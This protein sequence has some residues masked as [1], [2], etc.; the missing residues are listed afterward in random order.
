MLRNASSD[1]KKFAK[2]VVN[3]VKNGPPSGVPKLNLQRITE[4]RNEAPVTQP[5]ICPGCHEHHPAR[6]AVCPE[7]PTILRPHNGS[8]W[9]ERAEQVL[10]P[11]PVTFI[12]APT[13]SRKMPHNKMPHNIRG[14]ER[15]EKIFDYYDKDRDGVLCFDELMLLAA[16]VHAE[17]NPDNPPLS[18]SA[19]KE[20]VEDLRRQIEVH[21]DQCVGR[22]NGTVEFEE[23]EPWLQE[24]EM[25]F[26]Q[27]QPRPAVPLDGSPCLR[28]DELRS[29]MNLS[30]WRRL[31]KP[32]LPSQNLSI[33]IPPTDGCVLQR[34][35]SHDHLLFAAQHKPAGT[36]NAGSANS[37]CMVRSRSEDDVLQMARERNEDDVR[38]CTLSA[39][40]HARVSSNDALVVALD[41]ASLTHAQHSH[42]HLP[43]TPSPR[44]PGARSLLAQNSNDYEEHVNCSLVLSLF[45]L[46]VH[47]HK[48]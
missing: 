3:R 32:L 46:L 26:L 6:W 39:R 33:S 12:D 42:T 2:G 36:Y 20:M 4:T 28:F 7:N 16:D 37:G 9:L 48:Y 19:C 29:R 24:Q 23:F 30:R 27:Q 43:Q 1:L 41:A 34:S 5:W 8:W 17:F 15:K 45:A 25:K 21:Q 18:Q 31:T 40:E 22:W 47:K 44:I 13:S 10:G 14:R 11:L 35:R 38:V